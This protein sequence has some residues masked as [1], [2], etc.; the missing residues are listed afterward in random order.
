MQFTENHVITII[1]NILCAI[2]LVHKTGI[3][4]R[5]IK[6]GNILVNKDCQVKLC[7]FGLARTIPQEVLEHNKLPPVVQ[8]SE[9]LELI[10]EENPEESDA[11]SLG[12]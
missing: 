10:L 8:R 4:H 6:P 11:A 3:M 9:P 7:D 2:N 5:D 12:K 1:Y